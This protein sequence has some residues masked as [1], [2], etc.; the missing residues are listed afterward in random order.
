LVHGEAATQAREFGNDAR[1]L[2]ERR[3][4]AAETERA[5]IEDERAEGI[6]RD[7]RAHVI[8]D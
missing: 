7:L 8:V 5:R 4:E 6:A 3:L 1:E 2:R